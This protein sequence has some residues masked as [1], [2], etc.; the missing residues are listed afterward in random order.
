MFK[1]LIDIYLRFKIAGLMKLCLTP[2]CISNFG[3]SLIKAKYNS[4]YL[5]NGNYNSP[6]K[7]SEKQNL[8]HFSRII[9]FIAKTAPFLSKTCKIHMPLPVNPDK[10][11]SNKGLVIFCSSKIA[12]F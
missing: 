9:F 3:Y 6:I 2:Y 5:W 11:I 12:P 7:N 4:G 8:I 1:N 10:F